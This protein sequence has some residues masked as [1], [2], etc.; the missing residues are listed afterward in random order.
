MEGVKKAVT[1]G[2]YVRNTIPWKTECEVKG[3]EYTREGVFDV[4]AAQGDF[5]EKHIKGIYWASILV[6]GITVFC[7]ITSFC[8]ITEA[9]NEANPKLF[10]F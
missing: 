9:L 7:C 4:F 2:F 5:E 3:P 10:S 1:F 8:T 6:A